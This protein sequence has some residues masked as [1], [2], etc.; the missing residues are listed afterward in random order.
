MHTI[1]L[2]P[3]GCLRLGLPT[4]RH[5]DLKPIPAA[6]ELIQRILLA[7]AS[8]AP[9]EERY[10]TQHLLDKWLREMSVVRPDRTPPL[11]KPKVDRKARTRQIA[12]AN[13]VD[14]SAL[15]FQI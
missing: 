5:I 4:G 6:L 3:D 8:N 11:P 12:A 2:A 7:D 9:F 10:P 14:P 1:S 15:R 13:G